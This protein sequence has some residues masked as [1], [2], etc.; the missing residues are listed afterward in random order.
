[1]R[2]SADHDCWVLADRGEKVKA[3]MVA[4]QANWGTWCDAYAATPRPLS[5]RFVLHRALSYR[6]PAWVGHVS[7]AFLH[8]GL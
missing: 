7:T 2:T 3:R 5:I 8:A 6:W 1:M 4:R